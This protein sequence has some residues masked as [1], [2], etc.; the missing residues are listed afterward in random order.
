MAPESVR[1][2][3]DRPALWHA[4]LGLVLVVGLSALVGWVGSDEGLSWDLAS[5]FG[6]AAGTTLLAAATYWLA[7]STRTEVRATQDIA[8]LTQREQAAR[9]RPIIL[10]ENASYHGSPGA[11]VAEVALVNV[12]LGPALR[13]WV[14]AFYVGHDDWM[15]RIEHE[16]VPAIAPGEH[17]TVGLA[18][19]FP[20]PYQPGGPRGDGFRFGG[21]YFDRSRENKYP[22]ITSWEEPAAI[23]EPGPARVG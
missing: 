18:V 8:E 21:D 5:V 13:V 22:I 3:S 14:M 2:G 17:R 12:G 20:E 19:R 4:A 15:P 23:A 7:Y 10:Q 9:E 1:R 16:I 6:T 11:G